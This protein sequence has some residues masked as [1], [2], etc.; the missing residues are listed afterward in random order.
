VQNT[1]GAGRQRFTESCLCFLSLC[2]VFH[3]KMLGFKIGKV[4]PKWNHV[5]THAN[6]TLRLL[7]LHQCPLGVNHQSTK[8][9]GGTH[10]SSCICSRGWPS[11]PSMG[12]EALGLVKV[13]PVQGTARARKHEWVGW[14]TG[15]DGRG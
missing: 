12:G 14:E 3:F 4:F 9:H 6:S 10:I 13:F 15:V 2:F 5:V 1:V 11:R 7:L 8:T